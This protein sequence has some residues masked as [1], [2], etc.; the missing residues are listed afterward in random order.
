LS[1]PYSSGGLLDDPFVQPF[2][3]ARQVRLGGMAGTRR[4]PIEKRRDAGMVEHQIHA[5]SYRYELEIYYFAL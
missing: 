1:S 5:H 3:S 4:E 2:I